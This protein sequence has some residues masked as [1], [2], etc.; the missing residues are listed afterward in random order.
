MVLLTAGAT[1]CGESSD[2]PVSDGA[3]TVPSVAGIAG[4]DAVAA[5]CEEGF[6]VAVTQ[7]HDPTLDRASS[8]W[9]TRPGA[10]EPSVPGEPVGLTVLTRSERELHL[11][12]PGGCEATVVA[13]E[14]SAIAAGR[15]STR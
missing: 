7:V 11:A 6:A 8:A 4:P 12:A 9:E 1:G 13:V 15:Y 10:G 14:R 5:L 3:T 2:A